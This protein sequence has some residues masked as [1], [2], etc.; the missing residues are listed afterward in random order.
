VVQIANPKPNLP[1]PYIITKTRTKVN[2]S[3][4]LFIFYHFV[5]IKRVSQ[6]NITA[7]HFHDLGMY[8]MFQC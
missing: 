8:S 2:D 6:K 4:V 5:T 3:D 1:F 7:F